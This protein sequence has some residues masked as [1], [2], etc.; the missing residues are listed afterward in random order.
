MTASTFDSPPSSSHFRML[1]LGCI[2]VV[3]G[4]IGTSPLYA[5]RTAAGKLAEGGIQNIEIIGILSLIIWA[6]TITV[7]IKYVLFLLHADNRGEG[8]I[9]SLMALT[10]RGTTKKTGLVF[11]A[12]I[13]GAALF[14]G[15]ASITPAISVLSAIEGINLITPAF[16]KLVVPVSVV[17]LVL[18]F[19]LQKHGTHLMGRFFGPVMLAWFLLLGGMGIYWII[20][21]PTV[22]AAF[23]PYYAIHFLFSHGFLSFVVLG[24]VFLAVTGA[25]ALYTDLGHFGRKPIQY[26]WLFLV[27]PCLTL[28]YLGQGAL[29]MATPAAIDNPFFLMFPQWALIPMVVFATFATII[30]SQ[31]VITGAFS[32]ARQAMQLGLLP[33]LEVRHTSAS[34]EGQIYMPKINMML[35]LTVLFLCLVFESSTNL[36]A[37]YGISIAATMMMSSVIV[38]FLIANVW[39]KG[40][41]VASLIIVPF[42]IV[43]TVFF[44]SNLLK[45]FEGGIVPLLFGAYIVLMVLTWVNG[46]RYVMIK[47]RRQSIAMIDL[48]EMLEREPPAIVPGTAIFLTSDPSHA[49]VTM[50]QNLRHN[51]VLH[52]KNIILTIVPQSI[53]RVSIEQRIEIEIMNDHLTLARVSF[54]F[55]ETPN[56]PAALYRAKSLGHDIDIEH[57]SYFLGHRKFIPDA[58]SGL[59]LWQDTIYI[60]M[61]KSAI[62][63]TDYFRIPPSQAVEIGS[64]QYV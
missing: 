34:H 55:M 16:Q 35:M 15:E 17:I 14:F 59:P 5:F 23:S 11:F 31:A 9:L 22:L 13:I 49:P 47:A 28:N 50:I 39:K 25:E 19:S 41:L 36:A 29:L 38:F 32:L 62:D 37:A 21:F 53:P 52:E 44:S 4:D 63:A 3:Y 45:L 20:K 12:G 54:G 57:A 40:Y 64:R 51:Q 1:L 18:L 46:T 60:A 10:R 33:R 8:G 48:A 61:T 24:S 6:L 30:A 42:L 43:E 2:G 56:V 7:T 58:N 26:A 27:F